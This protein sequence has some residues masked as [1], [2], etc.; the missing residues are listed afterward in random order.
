M[1]H[2][3]DSLL[4]L[5]LLP[6]VKIVVISRM[7]ICFGTNALMMLVMIDPAAIQWRVQGVSVWGLFFGHWGWAVYQKTTSLYVY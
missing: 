5:L 4:L 1:D 7:W 6:A 3:V 2:F